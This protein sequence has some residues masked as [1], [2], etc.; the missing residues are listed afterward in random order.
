[1]YKDHILEIL[2]TLDEGVHCV[3]TKAKPVDTISGKN[4]V[5]LKC[6]L[7]IRDGLNGEK[8]EGID[9]FPG[10][11][12][13]SP[14]LQ[15]VLMQFASTGYKIHPTGY[16]APPGTVIDVSWSTPTKPWTLLVGLHKGKLHNVK[17]NLR[18]WPTVMM[19]MKMKAS[20][21][22]ICSPFGGL[23]YLESPQDITDAIDLKLDNVVAAPMFR[24]KTASSWD[25]A[26]RL[27]PGLWCDIIGDKIAFTLPSSSIRSLSDPTKTMQVWD[28]VVS[29]HTE[30]RGKDTSNG[31]GQWVIA[32]EQ[33]HLDGA[34]MISGYP[35]ITHLDVASPDKKVTYV[36]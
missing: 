35:I 25:S 6:N 10:T 8:A 2:K 3:P 16:Y 7:I 34:Y 26:E 33:L 24:Y 18:R 1:M 17:S 13:K 12:T 14:E 19:K 11:F 28:L 31:R 21:T 22:K 9:Q 36:G 29:M 20:P 15:T 5:A 32:D 27:K 4:A 23:V 30:L